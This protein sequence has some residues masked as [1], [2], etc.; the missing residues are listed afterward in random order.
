[1]QTVFALGSFIYLQ[2]KLAVYSQR[3]TFWQVKL[4]HATHQHA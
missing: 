2:V 4:A 1:M 3:L